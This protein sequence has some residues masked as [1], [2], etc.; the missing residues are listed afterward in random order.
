MQGVLKFL[1][2]LKPAGH[3]A[4]LLHQ[5]GHDT[6]DSAHAHR[7]Q[8][9]KHIAAALPRSSDIKAAAYQVQH[10]LPHTH[11]LQELPH[12]HVLHVLH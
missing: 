8:I 2:M 5:G 6:A 9:Q 12:A 3:Q 1:S 4:E 10:L 11:I 7:K